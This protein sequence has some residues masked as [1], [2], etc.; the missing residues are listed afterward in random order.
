SWDGAQHPMSRHGSSGV[1]ETFIPGLRTGELYKFQIKTRGLDAFFKAD[2]YASYAEVPPDTSSVVYESGYK[3]R[4]S[5]WIKKRSGR[6][7]FRQ[8]LSI[9]EVHFGSWRRKVGQTFQSVLETQALESVPDRQECLSYREMAEPLAEY[10][11]AMG[12]T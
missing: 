11:L 2:P 8:P 1:W 3:F 7:H 5:R 12:F 10:V 9:Y 6:E 4:D